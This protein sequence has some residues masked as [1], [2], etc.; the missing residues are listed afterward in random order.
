MTNNFFNLPKKPHALIVKQCPLSNFALF[1]KQFMKSIVCINHGCGT[2]LWCQKIEQEQ[3]YDLISFDAKID[4]KKND[5]IETQNKFIKSSLEEKNIKFLV[6]KN[7]DFANKQVLNCLLK[8]IER[9]D[10]SVY[11][12]F[13]TFNYAN[14]LPTIKS[15]CATITITRNDNEINSF[16]NKAKLNNQEKNEI[17]NCFNDFNDLKNMVSKFTEFNSLIN[18]MFHENNIVTFLKSLKIFKSLTYDEI[19]LF[20]EVFKQKVNNEIKMKIIAYQ[21]KLFLNPNKSL[22]FNNLIELIKK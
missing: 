17:I 11:I 9:Q 13:S 8:F 19:N 20:L 14:I 3:Y 10:S 16:L 22:L 1:L 18:E 21:E 4:L 6:I 2:C 7:I 15:R 5:I 12:I